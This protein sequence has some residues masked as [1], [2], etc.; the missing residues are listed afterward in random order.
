MR[1]IEIVSIKEYDYD[2][3]VFDLE[4]EEDHTYNINGIIVH[5]SDY[6]MIGGI[7]NKALES[8]AD[9]YTQNIKHETWIEPGDLVDQYS[10]DIRM[11]FKNGTKFYKKF[12]GMSTK[13]VQ[14]KLG[15]KILKTAEGLSKLNTVEYTLDGWVENFSHYLAS[16]M[17]YS[18]CRTLKE[19][20][21]EVEFIHITENAFRR[22]HK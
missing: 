20:I 5:N 17:S 21:G 14:S 16:A 15:N 18:N 19:F 6:V 2:G 8:C 13:E 3:D 1:L 4:I 11:M 10:N 7:F 9:T 12:R 22:F